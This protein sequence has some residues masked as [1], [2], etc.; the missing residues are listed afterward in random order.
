MKKQTMNAVGMP[1]NRSARRQKLELAIDPS[2]GRFLSLATSRKERIGIRISRRDMAEPIQL[3]GTPVGLRLRLQDVE[4]DAIQQIG[5]LEFF[6]ND[7]QDPTPFEIELAYTPE[8]A[9]L[10]WDESDEIG[11]DTPADEADATEACSEGEKIVKAYDFRPKGIQNAKVVIRVIQNEAGRYLANF[12]WTLGN[13]S[14]SGASGVTHDTLIQVL[15]NLAA[16]VPESLAACKIIGSADH[17]RLVLARR[18]KMEAQ[19]AEW[20]DQRV[21]ELHEI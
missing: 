11:T 3:S 2:Q 6:M 15:G 5:L 8:E 14:G 1:L 9:D 16:A 21:Y 12:D 20:I 4:F 18:D 19:F 17:V 10:P 7:E 13:F